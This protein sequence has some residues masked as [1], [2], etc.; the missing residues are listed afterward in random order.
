MHELNLQTSNTEV[1]HVW[2]IQWL[3]CLCL[4]SVH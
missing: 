1:E 2:P 3:T 4:S